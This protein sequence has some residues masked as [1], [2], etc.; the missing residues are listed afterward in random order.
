MFH[1]SFR[2]MNTCVLFVLPRLLILTLQCHTKPCIITID[3]SKLAM[4][5]FLEKENQPATL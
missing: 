2:F 1:V 3:L 5:K 4:L